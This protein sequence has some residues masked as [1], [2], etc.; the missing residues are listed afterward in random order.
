[1]HRDTVR[2]SRGPLSCHSSAAI[3]SCFSMIMHGW[4]HDARICTQSLEAEKVPILPWPAYSPDMSQIEHVW[5]A[6]DQWCVPVPDNIQQLH[7]AIKEEWDNIPQATINRLG[8]W[9]TVWMALC[10]GDVSRC[11]RQM[12]VTEIHRLGRM[13]LFE[14]TDLLIWTITQEILRNCYVL[15]FVQC[16]CFYTLAKYWD[17]TAI[18]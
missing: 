1:M 7:T 13:N 16:T 2:R 17:S 8:I 6:L 3:T 11:M 10:K 18:A 5:D 4:P 9:Q 14:L 15:I 12:V